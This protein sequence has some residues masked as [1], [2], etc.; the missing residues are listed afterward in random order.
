MPNRCLILGEGG[1]DTIREL[2]TEML[3]LYV[4]EGVTEFVVKH[5]GRTAELAAYA[6]KKQVCAILCYIS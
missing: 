6:I 5:G 2:W 3:W 4:E 1:Y